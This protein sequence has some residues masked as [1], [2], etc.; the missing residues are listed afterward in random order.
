MPPEMIP[1]S[2]V[3]RAIRDGDEST[4]QRAKEHAAKN[5]E[6]ALG[7]YQKVTDKL[8]EEVFGRGAKRGLVRDVDDNT[9]RITTME[10]TIPRAIDSLTEEIRAL[11]STGRT[12]RNGTHLGHDEEGDSEPKK[13][14][15]I[16]RDTLKLL[17]I[18]LA[19]GGIPSAASVVNTMRDDSTQ[20]VEEKLT[21]L[22][23]RERELAAREAWASKRS[24]RGVAPAG[25]GGS[26]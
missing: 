22:E 3:Q 13:R 5:T 4:L 24:Q 21:E 16:D 1:L 9:R 26:P 2:E 10:N 20:A 8:D 14:P 11:T 7:P 17:L 15:L 25:T 12:P 23:R 18:V 6:Q 19:A